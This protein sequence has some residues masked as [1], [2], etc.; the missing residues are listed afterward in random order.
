MQTAARRRRAYQ[1]EATLESARKA[2]EDFKSRF[3]N[4]A[5]T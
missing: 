4:N 3:M 1:Y 2:H 5:G